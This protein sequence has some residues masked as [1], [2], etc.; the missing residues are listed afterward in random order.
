MNDISKVYYFTFIS[1]ILTI[2][3]YLIKLWFSH[4]VD[5]YQS[6]NDVEEN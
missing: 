4:Y 2:P 6:I 5:L 1:P 3:P